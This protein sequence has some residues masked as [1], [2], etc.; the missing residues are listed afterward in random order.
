MSDTDGVCKLNEKLALGDHRMTANTNHL[1]ACRHGVGEVVIA[2][3]DGKSV[4]YYDK[5]NAERE[6]DKG[7]C[8]D[9]EDEHPDD[10]I[11]AT[12]VELPDALK[13]NI[14]MQEVTDTNNTLFEVLCKHDEKPLTPIHAMLESNDQQYT[15]FNH[16]TREIVELPSL[17]QMVQDQC[18]NAEENGEE[19]KE[20][21][22]PDEHQYNLTDLVPAVDAST[23]DDEKMAM[24]QHFGENEDGIK[25]VF[26]CRDEN[27]YVPCASPNF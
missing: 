1:L 7:T 25:L 15:F 6:R 19:K 17:N 2:K 18:E 22:I 16:E 11:D 10:V 4:K 24:R 14:V 21:E 20:C 27:M 23:R 12:T 8:D 26:K 13:H 5:N 9:D 3:C